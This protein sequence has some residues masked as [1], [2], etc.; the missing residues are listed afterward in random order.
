[1]FA[2]DLPLDEG[3]VEAEV[4]EE[5]GDLGP[6]QGMDVQ[7]RRVAEFVDV[8]AESAVQVGL[9]NRQPVGRRED[10][11]HVRSQPRLAGPDP[12]VQDG[13]G[14]VKDRQHRASLRR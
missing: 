4:L 14:P 7:A 13:G 10:F 5:V 8:V 2:A 9:G 3:V 12:G 1:M 11:R 6:E